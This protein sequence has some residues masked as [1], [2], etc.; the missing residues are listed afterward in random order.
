LDSCIGKNEG[1]RNIAFF[2]ENIVINIC[3]LWDLF[4]ENDCAIHPGRKFPRKYNPNSRKSILLID[5]F[6]NLKALNYTLI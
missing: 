5:P 1:I 2:R 6:L 4:I 3:K